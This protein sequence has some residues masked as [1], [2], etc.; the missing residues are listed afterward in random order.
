[1]KVLV[2]APD[3]PMENLAIMKIS[4]YHKQIGDTVGMNIGDPDIVYC[5]LLFSE[6][7]HI[8]ESLHWWY[9][10]AE[11]HI[12]GPGW[13]PTVKLPPEIERCSPDHDLYTEKSAFSVGRVTSGCCRKCSFC[14]VPQLEPN[15]I[16]YIQGPTD[17]WYDGIL[18]LFDDNLLAMP[19]AFWEVIN[20][21]HEFHVKLHLEYLDIR[22][23]TP[24]IAEGLKAVT[25]NRGLWFSFDLT[26]IEKQVRRGVQMLYDAGFGG[27]QVHFFIY[28]H[29][30]AMIP[31]AQYR[32]KVLRDLG[33]EPFLMVNK[34]NLTD[35]LK[36][37]RRRGCRPAAWRGL[38]P[39]EVF[40]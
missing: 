30:E 37:I 7:K 6:S 25:H 26:G 27:W 14:V 23:V 39:E 31:D 5:S 19:E 13:D 24:E 18:R 10:D 28:L 1:M 29:D 36:K 3:S 2:I 40:E 4:T 34:D 12:G 11:I 15:G 32:W 20:F 33:V 8:G 38:T 16:R 17:I 21:C 22:L 35:R 9:P